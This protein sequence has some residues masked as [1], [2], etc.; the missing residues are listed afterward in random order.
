MTPDLAVRFR[1]VLHQPVDGVVCI[2]RLVD[3]GV[4]Q[5]ACQ[6]PVHDVRALGAMQAANVLIHADVAVFD[7][8]GVHHFQDVDD[9]LARDAMGRLMCVIRRARQQDRAVVSSLLHHDDRVE[10]GA[11]AHRHHRLAT[12]EVSRRERLFVLV[13]D[14]RRHRRHAWRFVGHAGAGGKEKPEGNE[15][16]SE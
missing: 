16:Q 12:D 1:D 3:A 8:L 2:G 13:D 6:R 9:P 14:I 11:V 15:E 5:R 7:E 4:V 10:L